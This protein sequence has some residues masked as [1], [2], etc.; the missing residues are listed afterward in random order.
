MKREKC[1]TN[2][3]E[4]FYLPRETKLLKLNKIDDWEKIENR[5][6]MDKIENWEKIDD[7]EKIEK[8][9]QWKK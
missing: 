5:D 7:W 1:N 6:K 3:I 2:K 8:R 4:S 9:D